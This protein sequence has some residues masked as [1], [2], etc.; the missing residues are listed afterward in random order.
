MHGSLKRC[1][2]PSLIYIMMMMMM[3]I[4]IIYHVNVELDNY[5]EP[6]I[7]WPTGIAFQITFRCLG[8]L[9]PVVQKV[10]NSIHRIYHYIY[11]LDSA[12]SQ[13]EKYCICA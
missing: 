2:S 11:P 1:M 3:M 7:Q 9:A 12:I 13:Y 5:G 4:I 6:V 8:N 10:D